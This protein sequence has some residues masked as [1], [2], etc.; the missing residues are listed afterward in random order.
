[1]SFRT[2]TLTY[3]ICDRCG[4]ERLMPVDNLI[5]DELRQREAV[6]MG[7]A[8]SDEGTVKCYCPICKQVEAANIDTNMITLEGMM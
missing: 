7:Y 2:I 6:A 8:C 1:M 5:S 4:M 3:V